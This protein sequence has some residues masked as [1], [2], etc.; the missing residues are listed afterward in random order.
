MQALTR[1]TAKVAQ[2]RRISSVRL[3][4]LVCI[5][6]R[7]YNLV[8]LPSQFEPFPDPF[9]TLAIL[10]AAGCVDEVATHAGEVVHHLKRCLFA[11]LT[12]E[13]LP[14]ISEVHAPQAERRNK[15]SRIGR[16]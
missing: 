11:T 1:V 6:G 3:H 7:E 8:S 2:Y 12:H 10:V 14:R 16:E 13:V 4:E 15:Y 5:L 9:L